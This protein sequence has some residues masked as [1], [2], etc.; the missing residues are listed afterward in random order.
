MTKAYNKIIK[1]LA[2]I[3]N[4]KYNTELKNVICF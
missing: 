1:A 4:Y 3:E 2:K